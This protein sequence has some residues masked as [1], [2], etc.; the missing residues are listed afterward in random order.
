MRWLIRVAVF[1]VLTVLTQVGGLAYVAALSFQRKALVFALAYG[2]VWGG[3]QVAAPALGREALPC[4]GDELRMQSPLYCGLMRNFVTPEL[5]QVARDAAARVAADYPG[6][7][8]LTLDANLPFL[9]GFPLIPHLSH[10][11]GEKLDFAFYY[12][13]DGAYRAGHTRSPSG[14]FAFEGLRDRAEDATCPPAT[15]TLRWDLRPLQPLWSQATLDG[16]RTAALVRVLAA[17]AR[18]GRIFVEPVLQ[19]QMG[20]RDPKMR[21][22]GC[23]AARHDDHIHIQL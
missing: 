21:F 18:V 8:T 7:V 2:A 16:A 14:Y 5:A 13:Q 17:D 1:A 4:F 12:Q 10:G 6:T 20:L 19:R 23:R 3:V 15:V 11:D 9:D 22:Q